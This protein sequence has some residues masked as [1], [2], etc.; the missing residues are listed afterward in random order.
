MSVC[1]RKT[2]R[3]RI[4]VTPRSMTRGPHPSTDLIHESDYERV[5]AEAG[6]QPS[7]EE[8]RALLPGCVGWIAGVEPI[9][10]SL[11]EHAES[12]RAISRNGIGTDSIDTEACRERGIAVLTA[13]N[14]NSQSVAELT[15]ALLLSIARSIP[16]HDS[17]LRAGRATRRRGFELNGKRIGIIGYGN[18][19]GRVV[20]LSRCLG[21]IPLVFDTSA[22]VRR[23]AR[24]V[25]HV[26]DHVEDL[27]RSCDIVSLHCPPPRDGTA[28]VDRDAVAAMPPGTVLLNTA[29]A[30]LVEEQAIL[31]GYESGRILAYGTDVLMHEPPEE[32]ELLSREETIA[33]PHIGGY[34]SQ[35]VDRVSQM[36]V[37][38]LLDYLG[39]H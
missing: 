5:C 37:H 24:Q 20:E 31:S 12:L 32:S 39:K 15:V 10:R 6:K 22:E 19:G 16:F 30:Q 33:T 28:L 1:S 34:T 21:M 9:D 3:A 14:A 18:I 26:A 27:F 29:R 4:L 36:A 25:A 8:L 13:G 2:D 23:E 35:G 7:R 17:E 38:N 11:L